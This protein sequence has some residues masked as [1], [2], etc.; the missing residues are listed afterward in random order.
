MT[1]QTS[2]TR[3][4]LTP[5]PLPFHE[6]ATALAHLL[7]AAGD[8]LRLEILAVLSTDSFG[9][10]ELCTLFEVKQSGMSHHLKVLANAGLLT[11]R[12]EGNSV[13]YRRDLT[14]NDASDLKQAIFHSADQ[15]PLS[16]LVKQHMSAV[17]RQRSE[18]SH[19]FFKEN[20][21]RFKAQ[22]DLIASF[23]IY[24]PHVHDLILKT[25]HLTKER[26][27][28]VGPGTGEMLPSLSQVF[29]QV[30][31]L[32]NS[33]AMLNTARQYADKHALTNID[34]QLNDTH[35]CQQNVGTLDCIVVNMVLHHTP[36]P[37][38]VFADICAA[39]TPGGVLIVTE[40]CEHD[41][42]WTREACGDL[43]LG[44]EPTDLSLWGNDNGM[45]QGQKLFFALRNGFQIQIH[46]FIKSK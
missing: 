24:G 36:S 32:D 40:L 2:H 11:T 42:D 23:D 6:N 30:V 21:H 15:L 4:A 16:P 9:V 13:F 14:L 1:T 27:L 3:D 10:L 22:Q 39:L 43:W 20:A 29:T 44:F 18:A 31:A 35:Y 17:Y 46:Q 19:A 12:R 25:S 37:A 45:N 26:A 34:F 38:L 33:T 28:E 8:P 41:Q 5:H 7:K